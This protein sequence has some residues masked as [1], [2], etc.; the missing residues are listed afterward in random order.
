MRAIRSK[1]SASLVAMF[2][3]SAVSLI[4]P[5]HVQAATYSL[6]YEQIDPA[7]GTSSFFSIGNKAYQVH[8]LELYSDAFAP[9]NISSGDILEISVSLSSDFTVPSGNQ[10]LGV[11]LITETL[12]P[13]S[14]TSGSFIETSGSITLNASQ[15][16]DANCGNCLSNII[17]TEG[18]AAYSFNSLEST[19]TYTFNLLDLG[20]GKNII[21]LNITGVSISYQVDNPV[22]VPLPMALP[23]FTSSLV[24]LGLLGWRRGRSNGEKGP[25]RLGNVA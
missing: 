22:T 6:S 14:E 21:D 17:Y 10:F 13:I 12:P 16:F 18:G 5:S 4:A 2:A 7:G 25:V 9:F 23:M 24:A 8:T 11:N 1:L 3:L 19:A 20:T 15:T